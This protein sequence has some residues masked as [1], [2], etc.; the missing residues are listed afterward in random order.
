LV[1]GAST[2][3]GIYVLPQVIAAYR[4]RYPG[5]Q[6]TVCINNSQVIEERIRAHEFDL[7]VIGG[8]VLGPG[9]HCL[10][11]GLLDELVLVV[12]PT[13]AWARRRH[14]DVAQL[15]NVSLLMREAGSATRAVTERALRQ[16]GVQFSILME[17]GH[18]E[19]IK[20]AVM[21]GIGVAFV[22]THAIRAEA[23]ARRLHPIRLR[24]VEIRRHFHIIH[25]IGRRV[26]AAAKALLDL[27]AEKP[28]QRGRTPTAH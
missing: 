6:V 13:H 15:T 2:T 1:I 19:A 16:H 4:H 22:S 25:D 8:H 23:A 5:I 9:E 12:P 18:I 17:L 21:A 7:G 11:L 28:S 10:A 14:V 3:P 20:Q 26:P 27:L 24:G